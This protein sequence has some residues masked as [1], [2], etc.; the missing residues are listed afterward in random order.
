MWNEALEGARVGRLWH[1]TADGR[2]Q[3]RLSPRNC[4]MS[5]GKRGFCGVRMNVGGKLITLNYGRSVNLTEEVIETEAVYHY[6]PGSRILS[7]GNIGCMM[8]CDFCHNWRTSQVRFLDE[9]QVHSYTPEFV[10]ETALKR[11]IG[12]LS[13]TY[14]DPVVWQEFV[15]DTARLARAHGIQ[16]LYKSAFY[17]SEEAAWELCEVM[18]VFSISLKSMSEEY[19]RRVTKG[20]LQPVLDA[21][22]V[23]VKSGKHLEISQLLVT[24]LND[25]EDEA[26]KTAVWV[27]EN[28]GDHVPLHFVRFHPDYKYRNVERTPPERLFRARDVARAEGLKWLYIGNLYQDGVADSHCPQCGHLLVRRFG[29]TT[30]ASGLT[31]SGYCARCGTATPIMVGT[32]NHASSLLEEARTQD[33][34]LPE[35]THELKF[36]WANDVNAAHL[37]APPLTKATVLQVLRLPQNSV[38]RIPLGMDFGLTRCL[39]SRGTDNDGGIIIKYDANLDL[40]VLPVLDRAHFPTTES[41]FGEAPPRSY[42]AYRRELAAK[43]GTVTPEPL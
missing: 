27:L 12:M 17:I 37:T 30:S 2:V 14:N 1:N 39:I 19:Y 35:E 9:T 36:T 6:K 10:V 18:D 3:C 5:E 13:W 25:S 22:K 23:V 20:H 16:N 28:C 11:G 41:M 4:V 31:E 40:K 15:I 42:A 32:L 34:F 24:D 29:L 43:N 33:E 8:N 21:T 26:R 7:L 38:E